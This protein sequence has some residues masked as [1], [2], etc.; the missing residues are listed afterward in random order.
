[1]SR[2]IDIIMLDSGAVE[3]DF[4]ED[5]F[6]K[7]ELSRVIKTI[8]VESRHQVRNYRRKQRLSLIKENGVNKN[9]ERNSRPEQRK[10]ESKLSEPGV[11]ETVTSTTGTKQSLADTIAAKQQ[12]RISEGPRSSGETGFG[13][14]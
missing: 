10:S 14:S 5:H 4:H 12:R 11:A 3:V 2:K 1:M 6:T 9:G 7:R 8:Q 13:R